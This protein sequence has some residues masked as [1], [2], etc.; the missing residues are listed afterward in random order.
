LGS[1]EIEDL[2]YNLESPAEIGKT[3]L[4][5]V[6]KILV[7]NIDD[8]LDLLQIKDIDI[9]TFG[10][11]E[12]FL[13][14]YYDN[15]FI[16]INSKFINQ[17]EFISGGIIGQKIPVGGGGAFKNG[18]NFGVI[19]NDIFNFKYKELD[20][21]T[22]LEIS[23]DSNMFIKPPATDKDYN[24][25]NIEP[26][27]SINLIKNISLKSGLGLMSIKTVE[28]S[29]GNILDQQ[30]GLSSF[31]EFQYKIN[32]YNNIHLTIFSKAKIEKHIKNNNLFRPGDELAY[33]LF[34][35]GTIVPIHLKY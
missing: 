26:S 25:I 13:N 27:L 4:N 23:Y 22:N 28:S 12:D 19:F 33:L 29:N 35:I 9:I 20:F 30:F 34:G 21:K 11:Y 32:V 24:V 3:E 15:N 7:E 18:I 5:Q 14:K 17:I 1:V 16:D 31:V 2:F 10:E 8:E 6:N